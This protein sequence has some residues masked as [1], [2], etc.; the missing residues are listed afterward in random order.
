MIKH[1]II[2]FEASKNF[3]RVLVTFY[4]SSGGNHNT[5]RVLLL[6]INHYSL[7]ENV[8]THFLELSTLELSVGDVLHNSKYKTFIKNIAIHYELAINR[9]DEI[10]QRHKFLK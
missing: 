1:S 10:S 3:Q 5:N 6:Q 8:R 2:T 9:I 4:Y 7:V